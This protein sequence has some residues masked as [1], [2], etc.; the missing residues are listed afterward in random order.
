[1]TFF[2][3]LFAGLGVVF[4]IIDCVIFFAAPDAVRFKAGV[5]LT[6]STIKWIAFGVVLGSGT[7]TFIS[8]LYDVMC[9]NK[10]GMAMVQQTGEYLVS[11]VVSE[12]RSFPPALFRSLFL[13]SVSCVKKCGKRQ[14][15]PGHFSCNFVILGIVFKEGFSL[16]NI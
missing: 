10:E 16:I 8:D 4:D 13:R 5:N 15:R 9:F 6:S 14:P 1:M 12:V 2:A 11:F 3:F 7:Q